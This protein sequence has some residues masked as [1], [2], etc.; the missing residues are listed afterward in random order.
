MKKSV[1]GYYLLPFIGFLV[2]FLLKAFFGHSNRS[3]F[4]GIVLAVGVA[5]LGALVSG[6]IYF[7][8]DTRWGPKK[9]TRMLS[10]SPFKELKEQGFREL[11]EFVWSTI[12]GYTVVVSYAWFTG[13]SA[14]N[15][16]V[17]FHPKPFGQFLTREEIKELSKRNRPGNFFT[18]RELTWQRN[19]IG[20]MM[21]YNFKPPSY[22]KVLTRASELTEILAKENLRPVTIQESEKI[23][24]ELSEWPK[25]SG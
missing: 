22:E 24:A 18:A 11:E 8:Y 23:F 19:S 3:V 6:T 14:I 13:K 5:L 12:N 7:F 2:I 15:I 1:V 25:H 10:K 17:L 21:E 9:R 4:G 16:E 20:D